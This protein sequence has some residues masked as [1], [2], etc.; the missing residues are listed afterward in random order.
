[1]TWCGLW[2]I[3]YKYSNV[4]TTYK[5]SIIKAQGA[6]TNMAL[7][8]K[9]DKKI[10][11]VLGSTGDFRMTVPEG[12]EGAKKREYETSDG[13]TGSKYELAF[14]SIGGKITDVSF[15][16][17]DYGKN[18]MVTFDFEDDSDHVTASFGCN[19]PFGE[20]V[21]KK[22][23]NINL[24]DWVVFSPYAFTDDRGKDR[25]GVSIT[26]GDVKIQNFFTEVK[27]DKN[28]KNTYKN[29]HGYPEPTGNEED[30]DDWKIFFTLCR[31]FLVK[32]T[33]EN[34]LP[35]F[36]KTA[37]PDVSEEEGF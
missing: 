37:K 14:K 18:V 5:P 22:L 13:K 25:K 12:T 21:M 7:T 35:Q 2:C 3:V 20:D 29:L 1:M 11:S 26:Q 23:P 30:A 27:T 17:G 24:N 9:E 36:G 4:Q 16:E 33:E 15:F 32:Y 28:G 8:A 19:T 34:I 10:I 31:K 6:T